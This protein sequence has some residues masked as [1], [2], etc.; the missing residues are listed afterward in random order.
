MGL[1]NG[2]YGLV[3]VPYVCAW[4]FGDTG[5]GCCRVTLHGGE[6]GKGEQGDRQITH[7]PLIAVEEDNLYRDSIAGFYCSGNPFRIIPAKVTQRLVVCSYQ[8]E[9]II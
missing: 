5:L 6:T 7:S 1:G 3:E 8:R 2:Y 4:A 9:R